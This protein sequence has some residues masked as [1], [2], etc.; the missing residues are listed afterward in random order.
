[1][2]A[3]INDP[4]TMPPVSPR[5]VT[6]RERAADDPA[7]PAELLA[8]AAFISVLAN[9][10][11]EV[12]A[13]LASRALR[14]GDSATRAARTAGRW[15]SSTGWF[16]QS[17]FT[18]LWSER[19]AQLRPLL[20]ASIAQARA[21]GDSTRLAMGL[22]VRGW[23]AL[24][25]GDLCAAEADARTA[26]AA[27][28]LPA[29]PMFRVL[30]G[31]V[32]LKA[33]V[34]QGELDAAEQALAPLDSETESGSLISPP[35]RFA[36]GRLRV[37]QGR[38]AEGL[39]DILAVGAL[40][41]RSLV[42]CP[43]AF[44]GDQR[45]HSL[46]S[47]SAITNRRNAWRKRSFSSPGLSA[48][49]AHSAWR[50]VPPA[51]WPAV[52]VER[53]C[54]VKPSTRSSAATP[55][56]ETSARARRSRRHASATQPAH[57][58]ARAPPRGTR[59]RPP[60]GRQTPRRVRRDRAPSHRRAPAPGLAHGRSTRSQPANAGSPSSPAR[61]SPT[62][63]SP[64]PCSS[65]H[66]R[67]RAT[68]RASSA[69]CS[70]TRE[71]SFLPHSPAALQSRPRRRPN[72]E[73]KSSCPRG[74]PFAVCS[75]VDGTGAPYRALSALALTC[76]ATSGLGRRDPG[77]HGFRSLAAAADRPAGR[78]APRRASSDLS[79][80]RATTATREHG[81]NASGTRRA[82][83]REP[84]KVDLHRLEFADAVVETNSSNIWRF[85]GSVRSAGQFAADDLVQVLRRAAAVRT[86]ETR[87]LSRGS[88]V[89]SAVR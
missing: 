33:L 7:A 77:R 2:I 61:A 74:Q 68:S 54:S 19:Y 52:T 57:R 30:N 60:R 89:G 44:P 58:S 12:G 20:D 10:P 64:R 37:A 59:R 1:M 28:E 25:R 26:L 82:H 65:P 71:T 31:A 14:A 56:L 3:E 34:E 72:S 42:T 83:V 85:P 15:V 78:A 11:A 75:L 66:A 41:T 79:L 13:E 62:A 81:A 55:G 27:T 32:L 9:E 21:T 47:R 87:G 63:R 67:S 43:G 53:R 86:V 22:A 51:S 29:P 45:P 46:I 49:R 80:R 39:E 88:L 24:R 50:C 69:S 40:L 6:L 8:A 4:A 76:H 23:L 70:S 36:R 5:R 73:L 18:L 84:D 38:V 17:A 16:S 48:L 35:L